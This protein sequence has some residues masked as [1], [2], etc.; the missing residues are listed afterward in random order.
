M[1][2]FQVR[3]FFTSINK[4]FGIEV[5]Y[6]SCMVH[7][8]TGKPGHWWIQ[9]GNFRRIGEGPTLKKISR[10]LSTHRTSFFTALPDDIKQTFLDEKMIIL[11]IGKCVHFVTIPIAFLGY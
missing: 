7:T 2:N 1:L 10:T 3:T 9:K 5:V 6:F 4:G 8:K 11:N